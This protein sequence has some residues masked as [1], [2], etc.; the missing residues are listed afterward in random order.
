MTK[1]PDCKIWF[2]QGMGCQEQENYVQALNKAV[3][4]VSIPMQRGRE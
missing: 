4:A 3:S 1:A 2:E